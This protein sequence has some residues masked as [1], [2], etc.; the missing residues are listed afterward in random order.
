VF[1]WCSS[2]TSLTLPNSVTSIGDG[3]FYNCSSFTSLTLPNSVTSIGDGAFYG[4]SGLTSMSVPYPVK[5]IGDSCFYNCMNL[6]ELIIPSSVTYIGAD[7]LYGCSSLSSIKSM[8]EDPFI[9]D[10][11]L[12]DGVDIG[13]ISLYVPYGTKEK[14]RE[15][16]GSFKDIIEIE[17]VFSTGEVF[18]IETQEGEELTIKVVDGSTCICQVG[19]GTGHPAF[20]PT[21]KQITI[22]SLA[23]GCSVTSIADDALVG[24]SSL[25]SISFPESIK[26]VSNSL[27]QD[28]KN[29]AAIQWN[30]DTSL[31]AEVVA[32]VAN[33]P[34]LLVYVKDKKF[35][36]SNI[37]KNIVENGVS[38]HI[39]LQEAE[40]GNNFYCPEEFTAKK[41][42]YVHNYSMKSG[43]DTSEG[44]ET[45]VLPFDVSSINISDDSA[46]ELV[47]IIDWKLGD[48]QRPFWLFEQTPEGW[49]AA[50]R[51][52]ANIPYIISMP[53]NAD[54]YEAVY[55]ISGD[56][57]FKGTDVQVLP[58]VDI[59]ARVYGQRSFVPNYQYQAADNAIY[60]LN[61]NNQ[62]NQ[63]NYTSYLQ[64]STFLSGL[65]DVRPFEAY[66]M[67]SD[68][69]SAPRAIPV[70]DI[71]SIT[72][73]VDIPQGRRMEWNNSWY[74]L[75]GRKLQGK[76]TVKGVYIVNGKK[77]VVK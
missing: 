61:V 62:W 67:V 52:K 64:G 66:M 19:D 4:C 29:L 55:N 3:A 45:I 68:G 40:S 63:Y 38:E 49:Q 23:K 41:I 44:W 35:A 17:R 1:S 69:A 14:Y 51:I 8:I 15:R 60:A 20:S 53:N 37:T 31:P 75:D 39:L 36:P 76:P 47:S 25:L 56:V 21:A 11:F 16:W 5:M 72:G 30:A 57:S 50:S 7:F 54:Y 48:T 77:V 12:F 33:N 58:S 46:T 9:P 32:G 65:R 73:V 2:L 27:L 13:L 74:T 70:F 28:C 34:N 10:N 26:A 43:H 71:G 59:P 22:P 24:C 18:T 6:T 42:E